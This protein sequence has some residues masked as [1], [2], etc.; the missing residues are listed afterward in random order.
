MVAK[1]SPQRFTKWRQPMRSSKKNFTKFFFVS[2]LSHTPRWFWDD[3]WGFSSYRLIDVRFHVKLYSNLT[4][5]KPHMIQMMENKYGWSIP[6]LA[7]HCCIFEEAVTPPDPSA[8]DPRPSAAR[9]RV[10]CSERFAGQ[11]ATVTDPCRRTWQP[12]AAKNH[13]DKQR[14]M[15][16]E[17]TKM[18]MFAQ[19]EGGLQHPCSFLA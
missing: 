8:E 2:W 1:L 3:F 7:L 17:S 13:G 11:M 18:V 15:V 12:G 14:E 5:V 9:W 4:S 19:K 16:E 6:V 10:P